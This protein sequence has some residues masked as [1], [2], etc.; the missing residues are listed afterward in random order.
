[1]EKT[2][3]LKKMALEK[4]KKRWEKNKKKMPIHPGER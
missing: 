1:M 2:R 4:E 3:S